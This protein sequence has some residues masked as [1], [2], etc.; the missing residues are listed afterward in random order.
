MVRRSSLNVSGH[1][2]LL[3]IV[4]AFAVLLLG[5]DRDLGLYDEGLVVVGAMRVTNGDIPH[6]DF[7]ATYGPAQFY[8]LAGLFKLF[9]AS[10]LVER[11]WDTLIR[12][13]LATIVFLI[14][15]RGG[16]RR[17]AYFVYAA[18]VI[19][20]SFFAFYGYPVFPALLF[21]L[22]SVFFLFP[23]FEG[24]RRALMLLASG[25]SVGLIALFRYEIGFVTFVAE[26]LVI[27]IYVLTQ[28]NK[29]IEKLVVL[30]RLFLPYGFGVTIVFLPVAVAYLSYAPLKD[31]VFDVLF[32]PSRYIEMRALPFPTW[33][34]LAKSPIEIAIYLPIIIWAAALVFLLR[35]KANWLTAGLDQTKARSLFWMT[36][37]LSSLSM[38][39]Y[40]KGLARVQVIHMALSIIFALVL[41]AIVAK[42]RANDGRV[43]V[44]IIWLSI[45]VA[46]VPTWTAA[47]VVATRVY[48]NVDELV[49]FRIWNLSSTEEHMKAGSCR[50]PSG[51]E[52]IVCFKLDQNRIDVARFL[53]Q[54]TKNSEP[55]FSGLARHDNTLIND[56]M[57][58]FVAKR[59]PVTKWDLFDPG[60]QTTAAIQ[61]EMVLEFESKK[62]PF[63]ALETYWLG[64]Y[65]EPNASAL[66]SGVTILDEYIHLHYETVRRYGM[67]SILARKE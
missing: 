38:M 9:S 48:Q 66:S 45:F 25:A 6:H 18:S 54:H 51:L 8:V 1:F 7:Y 28:K 26:I 46:A 23:V 52:R 27:N 63:I 44:A 30:A 35:G 65:K 42:H 21:A 60:L 56:M 62:P 17:E 29:T 37:L 41:L 64:Q 50:V 40:F 10:I 14:A 20:L 2:A 55:I 36:V 11:L 39:F 57:L 61:N 15:E 53:Q 16:A 49:H 31:F 24:E 4:V 33:H 59:Q 22:L 47:D 67:I 34:E 5:M 3:L 58:Y 19:W 13:L 12:A 43:R 32:Y